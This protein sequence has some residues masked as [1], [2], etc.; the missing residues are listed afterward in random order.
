MQDKLLVY[1]H[2][3]DI[4]INNYFEMKVLLNLLRKKYTIN[5]IVEDLGKLPGINF[6]VITYFYGE[7]PGNYV[8]DWYYR[9]ESFNIVT[10]A[11]FVLEYKKNA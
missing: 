4:R 11:D 6:P 5:V 3:N 9:G 7:G 10:F 2:G 1:L 8:L